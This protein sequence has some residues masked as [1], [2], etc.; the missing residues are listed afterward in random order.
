MIHRPESDPNFMITTPFDITLPPEACNALQTSLHEIKILQ[1]HYIKEVAEFAKEIER[2]DRTTSSNPRECTALNVEQYIDRNY[3]DMIQTELKAKKKHF[4]LADHAPKDGIY[5][6][7][8]FISKL[9][10][11]FGESSIAQTTN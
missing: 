4:N 1:H 9:F 5:I 11:T 8:G 6:Q 7:K 3:R 10:R 2:N